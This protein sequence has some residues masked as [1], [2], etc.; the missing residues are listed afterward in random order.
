[1]QTR[2]VYKGHLLI[3]IDEIRTRGAVPGS[4]TGFRHLT[5][6]SVEPQFLYRRMV[7][8]ANAQNA[9]YDILKI[10]FRT[11]YLTERVNFTIGTSWCQFI[12]RYFCV[13]F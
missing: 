3:C 12:F 6:P 7:K 11:I 9:H 2:G 1:M 13:K 10:Y 8:R 5:R 4:S